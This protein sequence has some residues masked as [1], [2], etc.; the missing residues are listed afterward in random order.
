M[1]LDRLVT[2]AALHAQ[3]TAPEP[4]IS[5]GQLRDDVLRAELSFSDRERVWKGVRE[6]VEGNSNVRTNVREGRH[7]EVSKVWEW[8]GP[9]GMIEDGAGRRES[10]R[11]RF[12]DSPA[13]A[14]ADSEVATPSSGKEMA[15]NRKWDEGR[16]IY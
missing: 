7:G 13:A 5:V 9:V 2:Q 1:T 15:E 6:V 11:V 12:L 14:A 10:G 16:P 3:G 8:I 4:W